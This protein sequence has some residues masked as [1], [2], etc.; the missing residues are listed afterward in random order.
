MIE[1][2]E[3]EP[4]ETLDAFA[5]AMNRIADRDRRPI[6]PR[7]TTRRRTRRF[8]VSTRWRPRGARSSSGSDRPSRASTRVAIVAPPVA[9]V[10]RDV[11]DV[12]VAPSTDSELVDQ[13][14]YG[15]NVALLGESGDWRYVQGFD[16]S[17]AGSIS[18][19][20]PRS[21]VT[22]NRHVVAVLLADVRDAPRGDAEVIAVASGTTVPES[23]SGPDGWRETHLGPGWRTVTSHATTLSMFDTS[24]TAIRPP[25]TT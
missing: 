15:E 24:R 23:A 5:A 16:Q 13:A 8:G 4:T 12:R 22:S 25:M 19:T 3:T 20:S 14:H 7:C 9:I 2:T 11:A 10:R 18:M 6:P 1:P 17:S 21:P